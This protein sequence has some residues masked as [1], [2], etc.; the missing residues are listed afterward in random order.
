VKCAAF[1]I[2]EDG[3]RE[4]DHDSTHAGISQKILFPESKLKVQV[5]PTV[6][7]STAGSIVLGSGIHF[8]DEYGHA[9]IIGF[10]DEVDDEEVFL[11]ED[12]N[13]MLVIKNAQLNQWSEHTIDLSAYWEKAGWWQPE[14]I[15][16]YLVI[17]TYYTE[18]GPYA[19]YVAKIETESA[20]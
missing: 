14:E 19:F 17:S 15:S 7:T 13:R 6:N 2:Y 9:L 18:P 20:Q 8:V 1:A 4:E 10:S 16:V 12:G 3:L 5:F 11:Y